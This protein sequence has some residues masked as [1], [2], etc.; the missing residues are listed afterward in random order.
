MKKTDPSTSAAA[1]LPHL[2]EPA[3]RWVRFGALLL[4]LAFFG[5][6]AYRL[7]TVLNPLLIGLAIAYI[8]NPVV[9]WLEQR[10]HSA[11]LTV[12][13]ICF[14][15]LVL[16]V[17]TVGVYI[18]SQT[19][20]HTAELRQRIPEYTERARQWLADYV[21]TQQA[22]PPTGT[23]ETTSTAPTTVAG[24]PTLPDPMVALRNWFEQ[25]IPF[26]TEY[27][28]TITNT[29]LTYIG[30]TVS[31]GMN[32]ISLIV[33]IPMYTFFFLWRF[34]DI[35]A[36]VRDHLPADYRGAVVH[37]VST[38]D[39]AIANFF[40]GRLIVC[41]L[42]GILTGVGWSLVGVPGALL[43]GT[44]A[45][46]LNLVP[47]M[48]ILALPPALILAYLNA[49]E[50]GTPWFW[51]V[52]LVM[53]VYVIVQ[54]IESFLLS[55]QIEGRTSG[56]HPIAIVVALLIGAELAG[57]LGMLLAIPIAS[58][59]RTLGSQWILP[60][61]KRLAGHSVSA[62]MTADGSASSEAAS[63]AGNHTS[64]NGPTTGADSNASQDK[65]DE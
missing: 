45:G 17:V 59:L 51:P 55:P 1:Y 44:L 22:T 40:R 57:L 4:A 47:F 23:V 30:Q 35:V 63:S 38:I 29:A 3:R 52:A 13:V 2:P 54:A 8:L 50:L 6:V 10:S 9:T 41:L 5:W 14:T 7:K 58:T 25:A 32:L 43:L 64:E 24:P 20:I 46:I 28:L 34:N 56:L 18:G 33:L 16:L 21:A 37:I 27:G 53:G 61:V 19:I 31:S 26:A 36:S 12:V 39:A 42:V 62:T 60:E 48:S 11:R 15:L 49:A 65:Q